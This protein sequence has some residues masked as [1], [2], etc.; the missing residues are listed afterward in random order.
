MSSSSTRVPRGYRPG[1]EAP[2]ARGRG[3]LR[4]VRRRAGSC[5]ARA[6]RERAGDGRRIRRDAGRRGR[7]LAAGRVRRSRRVARA[8]DPVRGR[9][10]DRTDDRRASGLPGARRRP[11][12]RPLGRHGA[13]R[14]GPG[15]ALAG[16]RRAAGLRLARPDGG[17]GARG[18]AARLRRARA[19][20]VRQAADRL[21]LRA[22]D[23]EDVAAPRARGHEGPP[24]RRA[25]DAR[26]LPVERRPPRR[27]AGRAP[28]RRRPRRRGLRLGDDRVGPDEEPQ[29]LGR[30][31]RVRHRPGLARRRRE[32]RRRPRRSL[33]RLDRALPLLQREPAARDAAPERREDDDRLPPRVPRVARALAHRR[34]GGR[35]R[36]RR[37]R[38][39]ADDLRGHRRRT[40]P[41]ARSSSPAT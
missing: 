20:P 21:R 32:G 24:R 1:C 34:R 35:E 30:P 39:R 12:G 29:G 22:E 19:R 25:G 17:N 31:A 8:R 9:H 15:G 38:G 14:R 2:R 40:R 3:R 41:A 11:R 36:L 7:R 23:A 5:G 13:A 37:P 10:L 28:G 26:R 4:P 18:R 6:G 27:R 16:S 33:E